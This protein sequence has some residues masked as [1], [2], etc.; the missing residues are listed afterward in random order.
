MYLRT[1]RMMG[2]PWHFCH[3]A[4]NILVRVHEVPVSHFRLHEYCPTYNY[5]YYNVM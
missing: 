4:L 3:L 5:R 2:K 1:L